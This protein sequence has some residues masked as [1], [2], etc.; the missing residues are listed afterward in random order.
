MLLT[1]V[2]LD[3]SL[4]F[5]KLATNLINALIDVRLAQLSDNSCL[6]TNCYRVAIYVSR[7]NASEASEIVYP[8]IQFVVVLSLL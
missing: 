7:R 3:M 1:A 8:L 5:N 4:Q 6:I 2:L